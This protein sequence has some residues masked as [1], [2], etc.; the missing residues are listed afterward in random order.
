MPNKNEISRQVT[1]VRVHLT[2]KCNA[3]CGHCFEDS[4][5][6]E[7]GVISLEHPPEDH[8]RK[9]DI[10]LCLWFVISRLYSYRLT[11]GYCFVQHIQNVF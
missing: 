11:S 3:R 4:S 1:E 7:E 9:L 8:M 5:P 10:Q 6:A 2:N